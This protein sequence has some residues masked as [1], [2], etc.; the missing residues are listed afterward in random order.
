LNYPRIATSGFAAMIVF[1]LYGFLVHGWL[2][3]ADYTPYP[4]ER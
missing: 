1:F 3:A 4:E 2:I